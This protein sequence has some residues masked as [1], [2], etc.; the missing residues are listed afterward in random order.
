MADREPYELKDD[1]ELALYLLVIEMLRNQ[2]A[3]LS[4]DVG[5]VFN[6]VYWA[7]QTTA[8]I[9]NLVPTLTDY[10]I[11]GANLSLQGTELAYVESVPEM[12]NNIRFAVENSAAQLIRGIND[13]TRNKVIEL[14]D[15]SVLENWSLDELADA[16]A[17]FPG[18]PFGEVRARLIAVSETTNS[19]IQGAALAAEELRNAGYQATLIWQTVNDDL[20]CPI[21]EPRNGMPQG[22]NWD[23]PSGAHAGCRC[24]TTMEVIKI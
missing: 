20:V 15:K 18:S 24:F 13:T 16:L 23:D 3:D 14:L 17:S 2:F 6:D 22:S 12:V 19:Y 11:N 5:L 10:A 1:E 7:K 21:C 4:D 9:N 8:A